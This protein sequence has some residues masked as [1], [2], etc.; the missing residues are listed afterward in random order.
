M[1]GTRLGDSRFE[2]ARSLIADNES[3]GI[4][5]RTCANHIH[6]NTITRNGT[7]IFLF[8]TDTDSVI[9]KNNIL[10]NHGY[11]LRLGDFYTGGLKVGNNWWGTADAEAVRERIFEGDDPGSR[12]RVSIAPASK[13]FE[14]GWEE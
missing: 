1:E 4:N 5:F 7:G 14:S 8:E 10:G 11:D 12:G 13:R 6:H 2:I 9:E 3:K